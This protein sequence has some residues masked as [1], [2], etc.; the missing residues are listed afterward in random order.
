M[1]ANEQILL[2]SDGAAL[3]YCH[4][5]ARAASNLGTVL[6]WSGGPGCC[7]YLAPVAA[8]VD[9]G[10]CAVRFDARGCGRSSCRGPYTVA[11]ALRD[12]E[13]LRAAVGV[14]RWTLLGHSAG[15]D[16]ALAYALTYPQ[17]V[18]RVICIAGG[19]I[20]HDRD[21]RTVYEYKRDHVGEALPE[22]AFPYNAH[23]NVT[24]NA[25][26]RQYCKAPDL[27]QRIAALDVP[28]HYILA[29]ADIRPNWP[30]VQVAQLLR[31]G[32][33]RSIHGA[34]HNIWLTHANALREALASVLP[35]R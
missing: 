22:M 9:S 27:L 32:D 5:P 14:E 23:V 26:W 2:T 3:W 35:A 11:T 18:E 17:C 12:V 19:R 8:L 1:T 6:Y 10:Y 24:L 28:V 21:W 25:A 4:E 13:A 30:L 7:D 16:F 20:H 31:A 29:G 34:G 33:C 15:A